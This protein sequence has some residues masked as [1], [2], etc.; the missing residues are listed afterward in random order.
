[1]IRRSLGRYRLEAAVLKAQ[2]KE[3]VDLLT[4]W[5]DHNP[6]RPVR[7]FTEDYQRYA[8]AKAAA[9]AEAGQRLPASW[10][11]VFDFDAMEALI[12]ESARQALLQRK[13]K[14]S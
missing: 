3:N 14:Q 5:R 12:H 10:S 4:A 7:E 2:G 11:E 1:M 6:G 9:T 13:E 8:E